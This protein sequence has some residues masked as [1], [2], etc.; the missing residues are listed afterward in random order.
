MKSVTCEQMRGI[1]R[2]TISEFDVPGTVL[3]D[4]AGRG[5]AETVRQRALAA[6]VRP[7][8]IL[9]A[10]RGNN[11]GDA[12]VAARYLAE[13]GLAPE[14]RLAAAMSDVKGDALEH[15]QRLRTA[16]VPIRE[17]PTEQDWNNLPVGARPGECLLVDGLLGT[18][19]SGVP[20][21]TVAAA[22]RHVNAGRHVVVAIDVPSGLNADTGE[23]AGETVRAD[24]TVT[25]GLPKIGLLQPSALDYV[26]TLE[27]VDIGVPAPLVAAVPSDVEFIAAQDVYPMFGR[28]P[29]DA[30]KGVFGH[31]LLIGGA[32]GYAGAIAMAA[33]AAVRSGSG[34]V[35]A[36][37]PSG[38]APVVAAMAPEAMVHGAAQT[39][40]GSLASEAVADDLD[41]ARYT[42]VLAGPGMTTH[43]ETR[44]GV[45]RLLGSV[46]GP[47]I[48]DADALNALGQ[49]LE[50][51][52][53]SQA[54]VIL[55]PHPGEMARLIGGSSAGVQSARFAT[56]R[57]AAGLTRAVVIL[58]GAGT[59]VAERQGSL[60]V[61][62]TGNPG[63]ATGGMG[64]VLA[65]LIA[66]L[67]AQGLRPF[68]AARA[69][70]YLHGR[71]ADRAAWRT[72][73]AGLSAGDVIA[74]LPLA[75]REVC[76]R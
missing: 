73:E 54:A 6:P 36:L 15:G 42:A 37:V 70:V 44:R 4:R 67:A 31:V 10:G 66:G 60:H 53:N 1:D 64:D 9:I 26:G 45:E 71:A 3:M 12:F 52:R 23:A 18:G 55:T 50:L 8:I 5:V 22:I 40:S 49:D 17:L 35:T 32:D 46:R 57:S 7:R 72:S 76:G 33:R 61:N 24:V 56:A 69:G 58:K 27:V 75:L 25:M 65:G 14:V 62:L 59:L 39:D 20:R 16:G 11:G 48:L 13:W 41:L 29:R 38:I 19:S 43:R 68:D 21:G 28:R 30:H 63:M 74:E 34:L 2:R 51:V 47:L